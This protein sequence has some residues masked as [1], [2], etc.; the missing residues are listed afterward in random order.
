MHKLSIFFIVGDSLTVRD[1]NT[2]PLNTLRLPNM[3]PEN[4]QMKNIA[5]KPDLC[6]LF[7]SNEMSVGDDE[8]GFRETVGGNATRVPK[9]HH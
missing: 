6:A 9:I 2:V 7:P 4:D 5:N 1:A 8:S 3:L